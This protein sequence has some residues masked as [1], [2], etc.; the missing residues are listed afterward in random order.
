MKREIKA[1]VKLIKGT[2]EES[3]ILTKING[4]CYVILAEKIVQVTCKADVGPV[5]QVRPLMLSSTSDEVTEGLERVDSIIHLNPGTKYYFKVFI[6]S[7]SN[8]DIFL[9]KNTIIGSLKYISSIISLEVKKKEIDHLRN[10]K[11]YPF[12]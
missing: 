8:R 1:F 9:T 2:T 10:D 7:E 4:K 12:S 3:T 11:K 6:I 5:E